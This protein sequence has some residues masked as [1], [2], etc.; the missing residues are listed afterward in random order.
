MG[1]WPKIM[2]VSLYK[3]KSEKYVCKNYSFIS[4][5]CPGVVWKNFD[6]LLER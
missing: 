5:L 4:L 1:Q 3:D 2:I 6:R